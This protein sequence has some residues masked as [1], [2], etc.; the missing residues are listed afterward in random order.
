[1]LVIILKFLEVGSRA[2]FV[3]LTSYSLEIEQAGQFGLVVTLQGLASFAFGYERHIDVMRRMVGQSHGQF[4]RAVSRAMSLFAINYVWGIPL[5]A[6]SLILM[7][8][9]PP[10]L[11]GLCVVI[12]IAEQLMNVA[13]HMAMVEPRYRKMLAVTVVKNVVIAAAVVVGAV[14][15]GIDMPFVLKVWTAA[16]AVGLLCIAFLWVTLRQN[17][18]DDEA[19]R[20]ALVRQYRASW[21][22][23][24]L[25]LTAVLTIQIDRLLVGAL[26]SL[27]EAG[28]YFR[29]VLLVSM[30]FQ[31]FN[32]AFHNRILPNVFAQGR[33]GQ[34]APLVR[35]VR[36]EYWNVLAFWTLAAVSGVALH[37]LT[38]GFL[39][40]RYN[41]HTAY[42]IGL[43]VMSAIRT[44]ADLNALVF[45]AL[46]LE[47]TVFRLQL[48]SFALSLPVLLVLSHL[49]GIAGLIIAAG[50]SAVLYLALTTLRLAR[51]TSLASNAA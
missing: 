12:A 19:L 35:I 25:G 49:Y 10:V 7:A 21:T 45:N 42:F 6:I 31:V 13:Y 20:D 24:L 39:A 47:R 2:V 27:Q 18:T 14:W 34:V 15:T 51:M 43:L 37:G 9:L 11:I 50:V 33:Q 4:D 22:H 26:L 32:I 3:V 29:H 16:A 30:L 40:E 41:L 38:N 36:R 5:F 46:H 1:M 48:L 17:E 23:F 8:R 44:R 28:T